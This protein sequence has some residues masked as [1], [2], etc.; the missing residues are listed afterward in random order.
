MG[1][2]MEDRYKLCHVHEE[3]LWWDD[4]A[5]HFD[6][7]EIEKARQDEEYVKFRTPPEVCT[8]CGAEDPECGWSTARNHDPHDRTCYDCAPP[9]Y[10]SGKNIREEA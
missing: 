7:C 6:G 10:G 2:K 3:G 5:A 4:C 9:P 1:S 8:E